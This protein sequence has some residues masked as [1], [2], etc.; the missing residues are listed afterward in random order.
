[1]FQSFKVSE[2]QRRSEREL[3]FNSR[4]STLVMAKAKS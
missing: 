4:E 3:A 1:M 2:F